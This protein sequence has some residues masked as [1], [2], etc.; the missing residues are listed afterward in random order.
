M[1]W[2]WNGRKIRRICSCVHVKTGFD[3]VTLDKLRL[4]QARVRE[5][6]IP[7]PVQEY[8]QFIFQNSHH[9]SEEGIQAEDGKFSNTNVVAT[10]THK[11]VMDPS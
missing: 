7:Q 2:K 9:S 6:L 10:F 11:E 4:R 8:H 3:F 5:S 1:K